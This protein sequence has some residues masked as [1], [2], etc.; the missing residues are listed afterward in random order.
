MIRE[1]FRY[2]KSSWCVSENLIIESYLKYQKFRPKLD[3][4]IK[5]KQMLFNI[6]NNIMKNT[7]LHFNS[8]IIYFI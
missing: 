3:Y 7:I 8:S 5:T 6:T 2:E 4:N 1:D